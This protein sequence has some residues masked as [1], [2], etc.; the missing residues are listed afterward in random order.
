MNEYGRLV[1]KIIAILDLPVETNEDFYITVTRAIL[2]HGFVS[3]LYRAIKSPHATAHVAVATNRI[4][5]HGFP[6]VT[7]MVMFL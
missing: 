2:W 7:P 3:Q 1:T 5:K 6:V 4:N